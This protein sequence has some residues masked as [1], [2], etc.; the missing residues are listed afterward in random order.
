MYQRRYTYYCTIAAIHEPFAIPH[1][2]PA[3]PTPRVLHPINAFEH[4]E[5]LFFAGILFVCAITAI[6]NR[7][8]TPHSAAI[9]EAFV[10]PGC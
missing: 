6:V 1:F 8:N 10:R 5:C 7:L 3:H 4:T 9:V 2:S